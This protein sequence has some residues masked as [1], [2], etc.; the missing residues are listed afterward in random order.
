MKGPVERVS[1]AAHKLSEAFRG[2]VKGQDQ[3]P[4]T[5]VKVDGGGGSRGVPFWAV[6]AVPAAV[7]SGYVGLRLRGWNMEDVVYVTRGFFKRAIDAL[8]DRVDGVAQDLRAAREELTRRLMA[9]QTRVDDIASKQREAGKTAEHAAS[10]AEKARREVEALRGE[11]Q[12]V[13]KKVNQLQEKQE[14]AN[15]G[16]FLLCRFVGSHYAGESTD[17]LKALRAFTDAALPG[18]GADGAEARQH[19]EG[20]RVLLAGECQALPAGRALAPS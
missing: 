4:P 7:A 20:L 13:G 17:S 2:G 11:L 6:V 9:V 16:I 3:Q 5:I 1:G 12:A 18:A 19:S 15:K 8:S 10:S 14:S